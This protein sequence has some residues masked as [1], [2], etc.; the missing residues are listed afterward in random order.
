MIVGFALG[1]SSSSVSLRQVFS[2]RLGFWTRSRLIALR[3]ETFVAHELRAPTACIGGAS[4]SSG[5]SYLLEK[6]V[7]YEWQS[8]L[9][10]T[11]F[12]AI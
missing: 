4:V 3:T 8:L 10:L 1:Y 5:A 7:E 6:F 2:S 11:V 9:G 12:L